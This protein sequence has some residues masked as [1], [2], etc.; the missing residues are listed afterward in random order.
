MD[1]TVRRTLPFPVESVWRALTDPGALAAWFWPAGFGVVA[2]TD[3]RPD[4]AYR[5]ASPDKGMAVGGRYLSVEPGTRLTFTW[6]WDDED[7]VTTVTITLAPDTE[8]TLTHEGFPDEA[9]RDN[10][11]TGW[12]DCL[13]RLPAWLD[14]AQ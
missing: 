2:Q 1:L 3:P 13:D 14:A 11:V 4:G 8:L 10:H 5:I 6:Q 9:Q 7:L 12:S